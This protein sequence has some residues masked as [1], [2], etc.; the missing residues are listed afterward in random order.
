MTIFKKVSAFIEN[1]PQSITLDIKQLEK[2]AELEVGA[3][4][5]WEDIKFFNEKIGNNHLDRDEKKAKDINL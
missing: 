5:L 2:L 3:F 1:K 4:M